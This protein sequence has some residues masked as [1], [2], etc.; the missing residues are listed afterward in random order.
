VLWMQNSC[1]KAFYQNL[2][3]FELD[4]DWGLNVSSCAFLAV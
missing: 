3:D 4:K 2:L 1:T